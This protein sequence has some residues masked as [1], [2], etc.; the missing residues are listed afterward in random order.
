[1]FGAAFLAHVQG[2][3]AGLNIAVADD[4]MGMGVFGVLSLGMDRGIPGAAVPGELPAEIPD[5]G[6]A[7]FRGELLGQGDHQLVDDAGVLAVFKF[8]PLDPVHRLVPVGRHM[9]C[10]HLGEN[11]G[12][13]D[14]INVGRCRERLVRAAAYCLVIAAVDRHESN[15]CRRLRLRRAAV[16]CG[17]ENAAAH[18]FSKKTHKCA[19]T[20]N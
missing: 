7:L 12:A 6:A 3:L 5:Q 20:I 8:L 11:R 14:V 2:A 16:P 17:I 4:D 1:M 19:L 9:G 13:G 10:H 18:G 15:V